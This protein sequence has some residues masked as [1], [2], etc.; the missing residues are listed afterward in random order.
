M[1]RAVKDSIDTKVEFLSEENIMESLKGGT[2]MFGDC[3][4]IKLG[5]NL[6][7][8][9][10][11]GD[12][13]ENETSSASYPTKSIRQNSIFGDPG[14]NISINTSLTPAW[15]KTEEVSPSTQLICS[16]VEPKMEVEER[17]ITRE[18]VVMCPK[19]I[20]SPESSCSTLQYE[21]NA[22]ILR[23][24]ETN[25]QKDN[26][27]LAAPGE[28]FIEQPTL[29]SEESNTISMSG[30]RCGLDCKLNLETVKRGE[31]KKHCRSS[32]DQFKQQV[33]L[34]SL[35]HNTNPNSKWSTTKN[36]RKKN[37][38]ALKLKTHSDEKPFLCKIC[39]ARFKLL[40]RLKIHM[41]T[42]S[43]DK[44]FP[45]EICSARFKLGSRLQAHLKVHSDER[46]FSCTF[47]PSKFKSKIALTYHSVRHSDERPFSCPH[48]SMQFKL[49]QTRDT[50]VKVHDIQG[51]ALPCPHCPKKFKSQKSLKNHQLT[52]STP[53]RVYSCAH[54]PAT[55]RFKK[56]V[57]SHVVIHSN[58]KPFSCHEC[59][60]HFKWKS[61]LTNH[62]KT[63]SFETFY[64]CADCSRSFTSK[65]GIKKHLDS[66]CAERPFPCSVC[67]YKAR[68]EPILLEHF[69]KHCSEKPYACLVCEAT[70]K[71]KSYLTKH[72]KSHSEDRPFVCGHC[73]CGF[74]S[75]VVLTRH[76]K[77][78]A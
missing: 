59:S 30:S 62:L 13:S 33:E 48:C 39:P 26:K 9:E 54:C 14:G 21:N 6:G 61:Q 73:S 72:R 64:S 68:T 2:D 27:N 31:S 50:H 53:V 56:H 5:E 22:A 40:S 34:P 63:H 15:M 77:R 55:F 51:K 70:F 1:I 60:V 49:K 36:C 17:R 18:L 37:H 52:H 45:C 74:K 58:E 35:K 44:P 76:L 10:E 19:Y 8:K 66:H 7:I 57:R 29:S 71:C 67:K 24:S 47:C 75:K 46:P 4:S 20:S 42:H 23:L 38:P 28:V 16:V 43:D 25:P 11:I 3:T 65:H 69:R 32:S 41:V 12:Y 78:H